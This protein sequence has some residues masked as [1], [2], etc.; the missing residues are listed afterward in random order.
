MGLELDEQIM[1]TAIK[2][3]LT[4]TSCAES[5]G[6]GAPALIKENEETQL[7]SEEL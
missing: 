1:R 7:I 2:L 3:T 4:A 6:H 5:D